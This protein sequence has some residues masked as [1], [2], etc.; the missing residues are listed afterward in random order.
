MTGAQTVPTTIDLPM[1]NSARGALR[2]DE[3]AGIYYQDKQFT[4]QCLRDNVSALF[5]NKDNPCYRLLL[6]EGCDLTTHDASRK[7][8]PSV[9]HKSKSL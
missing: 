1:T 2:F 5:I 8:F 4:D 3:V 6:A 7:C 9:C